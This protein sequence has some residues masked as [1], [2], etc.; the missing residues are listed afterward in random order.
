[1][2]VSVLAQ[3][4]IAADVTHTD[5]RTLIVRLDPD[6]LTRNRRAAVAYQVG[7]AVIWPDDPSI[8]R[9]GRRLRLR[10]REW[11]L[12]TVLLRRANEVISREE[13]MRDAWGYLP[14]TRSRTLD[15]HIGML[16]R[17]LGD[18]H[19]SSRW[20][21]TVRTRGYLLAAHPVFPP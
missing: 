2:L 9:E 7:P 16:R 21:L 8:E 13:L 17:K 4:G 11:S 5:S 15:T 19:E 6:P 20:L 10:P 12:L 3:M 18:D 1:M 14:G